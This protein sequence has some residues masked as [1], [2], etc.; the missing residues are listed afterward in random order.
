[1]SEVIR[2]NLRQIRYQKILD[3]GKDITQ[4]EM[5]ELLGMGNNIPQYCNFELQNAQPSLKR[6]LKF[7][8]ILT[9]PVEKIVYL[10]EK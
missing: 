10:L 6:V 2:N 4:A 8:K 9:L 5:A 1:M 7:S 3:E